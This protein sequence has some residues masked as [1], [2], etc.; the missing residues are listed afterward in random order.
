MDL[1]EWPPCI[2]EEYFLPLDSFQA[3][4]SLSGSPLFGTGLGRLSVQLVNSMYID[5]FLFGGCLLPLM[6]F[7]LARKAFERICL[8]Q[9][10]SFIP[11]ILLTLGLIGVEAVSGS[12]TDQGGQA[13]VLG[14]SSGFGPFLGCRKNFY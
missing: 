3:P 6:L 12:C 9:F 7:F 5:P 14:S 13:S 2:E 11:R 1:A 10:L 8:C 4:W